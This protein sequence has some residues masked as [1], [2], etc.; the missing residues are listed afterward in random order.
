[1]QEIP[2][3]EDIMFKGNINRYV[4]NDKTDY[5][6]VFK[7]YVFREKKKTGEK[8]L[9]F[10]SIYKLMIVNNFLESEKSII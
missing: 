8:I 5:D 7:G 2:E 1:M 6:K 3:I 4:G 10:A 9:D